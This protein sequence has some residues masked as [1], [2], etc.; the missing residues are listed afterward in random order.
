MIIFGFRCG[1]V[2]L[3]VGEVADG[4]EVDGC[5]WRG[6]AEVVAGVVVGSQERSLGLPGA[7]IRRGGHRLSNPEACFSKLFC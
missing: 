7:W 5:Q 1:L 4:H 2:G 6:F 3:A